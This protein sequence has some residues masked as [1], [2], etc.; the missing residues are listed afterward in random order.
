MHGHPGWGGACAA[1]TDKTGRFATG[2]STGTLRSAAKARG[3]GG[4]GGVGGAA[5]SLASLHTKSKE[6]RPSLV[7]AR[8]VCFM[9]ANDVRM[10]FKPY[11]ETVRETLAWMSLHSFLMM[12]SA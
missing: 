12:G 6:I 5:A 10:A 2:M 4:V 9:P 7:S 11:T 3:V 1:H 8:S